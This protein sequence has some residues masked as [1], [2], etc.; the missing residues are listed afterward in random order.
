MSSVSL[1]QGR[2]TFLECLGMRDLNSLKSSVITEKVKK[3]CRIHDARPAIVIEIS[4]ERI[5]RVSAIIIDHITS[6]FL[7]PAANSS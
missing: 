3:M 1:Y 6:V 4:F 2:R 7:W 5:S